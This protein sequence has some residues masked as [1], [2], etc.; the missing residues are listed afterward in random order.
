MGEQSSPL[1]R[2]ASSH[3]FELGQCAE[4]PLHHLCHPSN[5][6]TDFAF[7]GFVV[8]SERGMLTCAGM[9]SVPR[10]RPWYRACRTEP[11]AP[12]SRR[13]A[14]LRRLW[15]LHQPRDRPLGCPRPLLS[16]A[17]CLAVRWA[18]CP[19]RR[20]CRHRAICPRRRSAST[21]CAF[22]PMSLAHINSHSTAP[23]P[24]RPTP[25]DA[26]LPPSHITPNLAAGRLHGV[27]TSSLRTPPTSLTPHPELVRDIRRGCRRRWTI[28]SQPRRSSAA[29]ARSCRRRAPD[30]CLP[31]HW[32]RTSHRRWR[33]PR[34]TRPQPQRRQHRHRP[35]RRRCCRCI[36]TRWG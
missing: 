16:V 11:V 28:L 2:A 29:W 27:H 9:E 35:R 17:H 23:S 20:A 30:R 19:L 18:H 25:A 14:H 33:R 12:A 3:P 34:R 22:P 13:P 24:P 8:I 15:C 36:L 4:R 32:A 21:G 26:R 7:F 31:Y 1:G 5:C 6:E 10:R